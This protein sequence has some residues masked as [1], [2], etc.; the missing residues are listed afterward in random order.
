MLERN[1][2][3]EDNDLV[4]VL[5]GRKTGKSTGLSMSHLAFM[6]VIQGYRGCNASRTVE[7]AIIIVDLGRQLVVRHPDLRAQGMRIDQSRARYLSIKKTNNTISSLECKCGDGNV[8]VSLIFLSFV[9]FSSERSVIGRCG[10][11]HFRYRP[12]LVGW[13]SGSCDRRVGAQR[14]SGRGENSGG[15]NRR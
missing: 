4:A 9:F 2:W 1:G 15:R 11:A 12:P 7:Q 14:A 10:S 3:I 5:T 8:S 6:M 13:R